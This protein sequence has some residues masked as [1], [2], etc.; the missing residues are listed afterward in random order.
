MSNVLTGFGFIQM[1]RGHYDNENKKPS[2]AK[3]R[4]KHNILVATHK[5]EKMHLTK[6][7]TI[8]YVK[9][10]S[11]TSV[12]RP[13]DVI[14]DEIITRGRDGRKLPHDCRTID[15]LLKIQSTDQNLHAP[16]IPARCTSSDVHRKSAS[17]LSSPA[18]PMAGMAHRRYDSRW[19]RR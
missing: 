11:G 2:Q 13:Q 4:K 1:H 12:K 14:T 6:G 16:K 17:S 7:K 18:R 9:T 15:L 10:A 8:S 3:K 5:Y 19:R